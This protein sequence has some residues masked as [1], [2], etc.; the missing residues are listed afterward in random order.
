M[1]INDPQ[2]LQ[3]YRNKIRQRI[4]DLGEQLRSTENAIQTVGETWQDQNFQQFRDNFNVDK[5]KIKP[6]QEILTEYDE[7][8]LNNLQT[9]LEE[10]VGLNMTLN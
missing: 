10:Y 7:V 8:I 1:V 5:E 3:D 9:K 2:V 6:L 4:Q